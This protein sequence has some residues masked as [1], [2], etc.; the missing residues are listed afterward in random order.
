MLILSRNFTRDART[1]ASQP[2]IREEE[3]TVLSRKA[4]RELSNSKRDATISILARVKKTELLKSRSSLIRITEGCREDASWSLVSFHVE[5]HNGFSRRKISKGGTP[6]RR[7]FIVRLIFQPSS[8]ILLAGIGRDEVKPFPFPPDLFRS[9]KHPYSEEIRF[10]TLVV[11]STSCH[12][13]LDKCTL[14]F[15]STRGGHPWWN[16]S[17]EK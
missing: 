8:K 12:S 15:S 10:I 4:R 13:S 14:L 16:Y 6:F 5:F 1:A 17:Y 7:E 9:N 2:F 3:N 11:P